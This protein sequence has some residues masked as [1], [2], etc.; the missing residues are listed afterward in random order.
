MMIWRRGVVTEVSQPWAGVQELTVALVDPGDGDPTNVRALSYTEMTGLGDVGDVVILTTAALHRE[1]G[2][3][4]YA[5]VVAFP[6]RLPADPP[7]A[8][9]HIVVTH[10]H[11]LL[12][13][14]LVVY[15]IDAVPHP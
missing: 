8:P 10:Y 14:H 11:H 2:T 7:P 12:T 4:G 5:F 1:L 6:D 9:G 15:V 13:L 3:G